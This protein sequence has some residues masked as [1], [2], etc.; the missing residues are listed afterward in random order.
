MNIQCGV[1]RTFRQPRS[2]INAP[3]SLLTT[4]RSSGALRSLFAS[5]F[6]RLADGREEAGR[7]ARAG[8]RMPFARRRDRIPLPAFF[9]SPSHRFFI[10]KSFFLLWGM[11]Y[12]GQGYVET[13]ETVVARKV[14][15]AALA[16]LYDMR[17]GCDLRNHWQKAENQN[18]W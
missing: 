18:H 15:C 5:R 17:K 13:R 11:A 9:P 16:D 4:R 3:E 1:I 6:D 8:P 7:L 2:S 10:V 12:R 14:V